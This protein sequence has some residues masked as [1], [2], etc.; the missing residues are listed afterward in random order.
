MII[1]PEG[2]TS[3]RLPSRDT[4]YPQL[5]PLNGYLVEL[6]RNSPHAQR[7]KGDAI[8][9]AG[10]KRTKINSQRRSSSKIPNSN[11]TSTRWSFL[12]DMFVRHLR[13]RKRLISLK[14]HPM[15]RR[16]RYV[17][18]M[19]W[20]F[21]RFHHFSLTLGLLMIISSFAQRHQSNLIIRLE[22]HP[23]S[24][25]RHPMIKKS[26]AMLISCGSHDIG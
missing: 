22:T 4:K 17:C 10:A 2:L 15:L 14:Q 24:H 23:F 11:D 20:S 16:A 25:H 3:I 13:S 12:T 9:L 6:S 1:T 7:G 26:L 18:L 5:T 21:L 19:W 8:E